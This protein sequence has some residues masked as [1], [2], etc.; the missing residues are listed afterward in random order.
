MEPILIPSVRKQYG[1]EPINMTLHILTSGT[2]PQAGIG[3]TPLPV[4]KAWILKM[5]LSVKCVF[6]FVI[7]T[8]DG[9]RV[10]TIL[11]RYRRQE[12]DMLSLIHI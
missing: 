9:N 3:W 11:V 7:E 10:T 4:S 8:D 6:D 12:G 2:D 1:S 5:V